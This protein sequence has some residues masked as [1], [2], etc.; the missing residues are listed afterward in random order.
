MHSVNAIS[1][2][3]SYDWTDVSWQ[4]GLPQTFITQ[5][6]RFQFGLA[7]LLFANKT[8]PF[9]TLFV[10]AKL[11]YYGRPVAAPGFAFGVFSDVPDSFLF[12]I[13]TSFVDL[14]TSYWLFL[15]SFGLSTVLPV[16]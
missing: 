7:A 8:H 10:C 1:C 3:E 9:A 14:N 4:P 6:S 13:P 16:V 5:S 12:R 11:G 15:F 2:Y